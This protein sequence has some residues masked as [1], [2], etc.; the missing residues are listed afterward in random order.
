MKAL[1]K[2]DWSRSQR[3]SSKYASYAAIDKILK[4]TPGK[5]TSFDKNL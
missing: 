4:T 1:K 5:S 3:Q 2:K